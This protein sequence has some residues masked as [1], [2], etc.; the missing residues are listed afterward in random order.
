MLANAF[1]KTLIRNKLGFDLATD[2][3]LNYI[4]Q[5]EFV[6]V[7]YNGVLLGNY[8][9]TEPVETGAGR[10]DITE[11]DTTT[12]FMIEIERER[13]EN[14][15]TYIYSKNGIRFAIN[16]PEV[17]TNNQKS[18][19]ENVLLNVEKSLKTYRMSEYSKYIDVDSF[20]NYY[21]VSEIFK[22]VDFNFSST[23]FYYKNNKLYAGPI[24]DLD[25]SCGNASKRFYK[26]YYNGDKAYEK[27]TCTEM[28]WYGFLIKSDEFVAKVNTRLAAMKNRIA[29]MY[30]ANSLGISQIDKLTSLYAESFARNYDAAGNGGAGW[31]LTKRYSICDNPLGLEYDNQPAT[32]K[33]SVDMLRTWLN[34]RVTYLEGAW[35]EIHN[36]GVDGLEATKKGATKV[37]LSWFIDG[38]ADGVEVYIK[39]GNG[40]YKLYKTINGEAEECIVKKIKP[41]IKYYF[42]VRTFARSGSDVTYSAFAKVSKKL[43]ISKVKFKKKINNNKV[44]LSWKK[45]AGADGYTVYGGKDKKHLKVLKNLKAKKLKFSKKG[46][47]YTGK[48]VF[49]V[50]AFTKSGKK[51]YY[52]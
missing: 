49:K 30:M 2:M 48:Y 8:L 38:V 22:A 11:D 25:L 15:V 7:Y 26:G 40:K 14:D 6:D 35:K 37:K 5:S 1:D 9:I 43:K 51:K 42:K 10:V 27:L 31:S 41:G 20:V 50:K 47:K 29:N 3:G 23:R 17:P 33:G 24:W 34:N 32:Y 4:S 16:S 21:I 18:N 44:S 12:D 19:I 45:V 36:N 52:S 39:K 46:R 13:F 28:K